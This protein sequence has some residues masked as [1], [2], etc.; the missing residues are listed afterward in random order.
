MHKEII[1]LS[2]FYYPEFTGGAE[3]NDYSLISRLT[4]ARN[5]KICKMKC[6]EVDLNFIKDNKSSKFIVSNFVTLPEAVKK[7]LISDCRYIIY[8]HDHKY[9]KK[10]NPIFYKDFVAPEQELANQQF[11]KNAESVVCLTKL[12]VDVFKAN[13]GLNNASRIGSS[14]WTDSDLD[15]INKIRKKNKK[16]C[17]A[18]MDSENPIKKKYQCI[19]YCKKNNINFELIKDNRHRHF[20]DRLSEYSGLVFMTGHLETCCRIIVEA[21]MLNLK[22]IT[23]KKLIGAASEESFKLNGEQ[24][25]DEIRR[26][27]ANSVNLFFGGKQ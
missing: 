8:E 11:Y 25:V 13:T 1:F 7:Y 5:L 18:I 16:N 10:R 20:L 26:V 21:K 23:Q 14:V 22:V 9:L 12:A 17:F 19:E 2:D 15:Y 24:L 3:L 27:S 4:E 6:A